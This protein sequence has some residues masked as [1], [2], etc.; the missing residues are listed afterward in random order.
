MVPALGWTYRNAFIGFIFIAETE[1]L[2]IIFYLQRSSQGP[3]QKFILVV[4][5]E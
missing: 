1:S 4:M 3:S 2:E 5:G